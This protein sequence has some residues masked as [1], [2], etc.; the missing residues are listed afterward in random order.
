MNYSISQNSRRV[1]FVVVGA[2]VVG[3]SVAR[4][5]ALRGVSVLVLDRSPRL[6]GGCSYANAAIVAPHHV[7]PLATPTLL[8]E[9]PIQMLRRPPAVRVTPEVSL[10]PWMGRLLSS[11][12]GAKL[13][14]ARLSELAKVST[15]LHLQLAA[16]GLTDLRKSGAVDVYLRSSPKPSHKALTLDRLQELEPSIEGVVGA[17]YDS[18][19]WIVESRGYIAAMLDDA[20]HHGAEIS[21]GVNVERVLVDGGHVEGLVTSDGMIRADHVVLA[22]GLDT[23]AL[24][25]QVG[26]RLPLRGGRGYVVDVE[27]P[28][29]GGPSRPVRIKEHRIVV[30]PLSDRVRICG[31]IEFGKESRLAKDSRGEL[32]RQVALTVLPALRDQ[33]VIDRWAGERPCTS[34]G[35]PIVGTSGLVS[36]LSVAAGHGMWGMILAPVT[37]RLVALAAVEGKPKPHME[38]LG[39]ERF[40]SRQRMLARRGPRS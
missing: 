14:S 5:L 15:E 21:L 40:S 18:E 38:W 28:K 31:S 35:V 13:A 37:A 29:F 9:A 33:P 8:R 23:A 12:R 1:D 3:A 17:T 39:P 20:A 22:G 10:I 11:T 24:A 6:G 16:D 27:K 2:G 32:L 25:G 26:L 7:T 34:D 36:N 19:E 4:E 30:T